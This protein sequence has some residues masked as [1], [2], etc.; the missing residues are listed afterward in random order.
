MIYNESIFVE[1]VNT[2]FEEII[3]T[4]LLEMTEKFLFDFKSIGLI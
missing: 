4:N 2:C 1:Q 3:V